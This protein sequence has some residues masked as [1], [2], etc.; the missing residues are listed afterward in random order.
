MQQEA[1]VNQEKGL[2]FELHRPVDAFASHSGSKIDPV[3]FP[4]EL[5]FEPPFVEKGLEP[6]A[7][8]P[9]PV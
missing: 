4:G 9:Q 2:V 7:K 3:S 1:V 6:T 5:Q 8:R